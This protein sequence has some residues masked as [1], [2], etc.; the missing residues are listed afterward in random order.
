M[1]V[2]TPQVRC[3]AC[4]A[5][6]I[7]FFELRNGDPEGFLYSPQPR[8]AGPLLGFCYLLEE[9]AAERIVGSPDRT[10]GFAHKL[11]DKVK[12]ADRCEEPGQGTKWLVDVYLLEV[13]LPQ[14]HSIILVVTVGTVDKLFFILQYTL[15]V[16]Q[17]PALIVL[18]KG[19]L[20]P[21]SSPFGSFL[22]FDMNFDVRIPAGGQAPDGTDPTAPSDRLLKAATCRSEITQKP[23]DVEEVGFSRCVGPY[24]KHAVL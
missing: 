18:G 24:E 23:E 7:D 2:F 11:W 10:I 13:G 19:E 17:R 9:I 8:I 16:E 5:P 6:Q 20:I 21:P 15:H 3:A 12:V 4:I 1:L 14:P 22:Q